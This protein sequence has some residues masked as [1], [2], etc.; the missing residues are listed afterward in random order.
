[1]SSRVHLLLVLALVQ[2]SPTVLADDDA[3][4]RLTWM[5]QCQ[6]CHRADGTATGDEVPAIAGQVSRFLHVDGGREFLVRVPGVA[7]A[8]LGDADL[9]ALVNWMLAEFDP[10]HLPESF[11]PYEAAEV[12][13]L[14]TRPLGPEVVPERQR[15][16]TQLKAISK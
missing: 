11:T 9:A 4:N 5:L 14:R 8:P 12:A 3:Q 13:A 16:M 7:T 1:M 6:G 15:L 2:A 10:D